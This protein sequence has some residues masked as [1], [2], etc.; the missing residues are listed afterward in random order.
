MGGTFLDSLDVVVER[1]EE[2]A[3]AKLKP[4]GK[5]KV[6]LLNDDYTPMD[7][8][9]EVL[10]R[11]FGYNEAVATELMLQV[12]YQGRAICGLFTRD[13]AETKVHQVTVYAEQHE[14]PLRCTM[15][16]ED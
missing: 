13:I 16:P 7:F 12:H 14:F 11:Y 3:E 10:E 1:Q 15:E 8:V 5:F 4:P 6:I 9:V 2:E